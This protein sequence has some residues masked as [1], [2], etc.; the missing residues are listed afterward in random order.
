MCFKNI[1]CCGCCWC[2]FERESRIVECDNPESHPPGYILEL[3][4]I[5]RE[6]PCKREKCKGAYEAASK[7][8]KQEREEPKKQVEK[9]E[10][11]KKVAKEATAK[12]KAAAKQTEMCTK[13]QNI[14]PC[15][16]GRVGEPHDVHKCE[17]AAQHHKLPSPEHE[18]P[19]DI[20]PADFFCDNCL[21]HNPV[22]KKYAAEKEARLKRYE[23]S[24]TQYTYPQE[25]LDFLQYNWEQKE[26]FEWE[27]AV[28]KAGK[29][30]A[31]EN[32]AKEKAANKEKA[33]ALAERKKAD[34]ET[35]TKE[36]A[37]AKQT[38]SKEATGG[39]VNTESSLR[40]RDM[41]KKLIK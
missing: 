35:A 9:K 40:K 33:K 15:C 3:K 4:L 31:K 18:S 22:A 27:K 24:R 6:S 23:K 21:K 14:C 11:K 28:K 26:S 41:L 32:A 2:R 8:E 19:S 13:V 36:K 20:V 16:S 5:A 1:P 39:K 12:E 38:T 29:L 30:K 17:D 37:A 34:K 25:T 10:E 7:K